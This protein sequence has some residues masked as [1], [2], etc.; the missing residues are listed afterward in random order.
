MTCIQQDGIYICDDLIDVW[1]FS[2]PKSYGDPVPYGTYMLRPPTIQFMK[3][4]EPGDEIKISR[5]IDKIWTRVTNY[6]GCETITAIVIGNLALEHPFNVGD[7]IQYQF[8]NVYEV[9]KK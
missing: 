3:T 6:D 5:G 7:L 9:K 2:T 1:S 4:I 8:R